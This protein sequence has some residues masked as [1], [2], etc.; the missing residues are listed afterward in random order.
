MLLAMPLS[1]VT[2]KSDTVSIGPSCAFLT[3]IVHHNNSLAMGTG[4]FRF[5]NYR[6]KG[7]SVA[8]LILLISL[9]LLIVSMRPLTEQG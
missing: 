6:D 5:L 9:P 1:D 2:N 4:K 3:P 7:L 8:L